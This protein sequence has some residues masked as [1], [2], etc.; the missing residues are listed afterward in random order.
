[1]LF[2]VDIVIACSDLVYNIL[3]Y[4][5]EQNAVITYM[6]VKHIKL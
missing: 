4:Q 5:R 2:K 6:I 1:M 3:V